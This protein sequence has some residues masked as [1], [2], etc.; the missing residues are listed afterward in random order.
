[1]AALPLTDEPVCIKEVGRSE[2]LHHVA[3]HANAAQLGVPGPLTRLQHAPT[4][5]C[6]RTLPGPAPVHSCDLLSWGTVDNVLGD[7]PG[8]QG[9][10]EIDIAFGSVV[11]AP[12]VQGCGSVGQGI[13]EREDSVIITSTNTKHTW[14]APP[15]PYG[16]L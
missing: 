15:R 1:M 16:A 10:A 5:H 12:S 4:G 2:P 6:L 14:S 11:V 8:V 13:A 7:E 9:L 3:A